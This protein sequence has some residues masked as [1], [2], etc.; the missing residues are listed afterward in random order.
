VAVKA[1]IPTLI[2]LEQVALVVVLVCRK[3]VTTMVVL[4]L[5][6]VRVMLVVTQLQ[7]WAHFLHL[8]AVAQQPLVQ[9]PHL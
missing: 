3:A 1:V 4:L 8:V 6:L 2:L 5:H 9:T 7:T